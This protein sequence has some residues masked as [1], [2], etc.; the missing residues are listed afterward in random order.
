MEIPDIFY[1]IYFYGNSIEYP[2]IIHIDNLIGYSIE[3]PTGIPIENRIRIPI[4]IFHT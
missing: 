3:S 2:I 1:R 4:G